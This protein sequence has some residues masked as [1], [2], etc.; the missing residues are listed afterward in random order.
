VNRI[1]ATVFP[2]IARTRARRPAPASPVAR[3]GV[4]RRGSQARGHT[5]R[6]RRNVRSDASGAQ[7]TSMS[8]R[9]RTGSANVTGERR[10]KPPPGRGSQR[11]VTG[12]NRGMCNIRSGGRERQ[13]S[14]GT[15]HRIADGD[16][17]TAARAGA[18]TIGRR[19]LNRLPSAHHARTSACESLIRRHRRGRVAR[20]GETGR[21]VAV[22]LHG[23]SVADHEGA[24]W[25][26]AGL[27][28]AGR[29]CGQQLI[30]GQ[31]VT[32][33]TNDKQQ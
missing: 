15:A 33:E 29:P 13:P 17:R 25:V 2:S 21:E 27:Q 4:A 12:A 8:P 6:P 1:F 11:T 32:Q 18:V 23:S 31:A 26:R 7:R 20:H 14:I 30:V 19:S 16:W 10:T 5:Q 3:R 9:Q 28:R 22:Q 24:R